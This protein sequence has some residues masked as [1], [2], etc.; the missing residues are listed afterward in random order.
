[1][2]AKINS[3]G[4]SSTGRSAVEPVILGFGVYK[5]SDLLVLNGLQG[6]VGGGDEDRYS[7]GGVAEYIYRLFLIRGHYGP[8][9]P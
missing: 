7:G 8:D 6:A 4:T 1:M 5:A 2:I 3:G 9:S